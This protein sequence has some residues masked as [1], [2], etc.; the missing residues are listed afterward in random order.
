MCDSFSAREHERG[1]GIKND[2]RLPQSGMAG[3]I[4][5]GELRLLCSGEKLVAVV[6]DGVLRVLEGVAGEDQYDTL[7][8]GDL[9]EGDKLFQAGERDGGGGFAPYA[10]RADLSLRERNLLLGDL[11]APAAEFVDDC[12][13]LAP[14]GG[15][16]DA[17]RRGARVRRDRLHHAVGVDEPAVERV[18]AFR[19][20]DADLRQARDEA[21]LV[22][23][24]EAFA[25]RSR[26][27]EVSPGDDD[28]LGNL[29]VHL[30]DHLEGGRLLAFEPVRVDGV[31]QVNRELLHKVGEQI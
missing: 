27:G 30:L 1:V 19:L 11:F 6:V 26:V 29:P 2:G 31:E 20:D 14:R 23:L 24:G 7:L 25:E 15:V 22:H 28:V 5:S 9:A 4:G 13:C 21:E 18:G 17:D 3:L 8:G 10:F 16:A 12:R